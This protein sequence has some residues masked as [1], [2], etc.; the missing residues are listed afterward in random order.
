MRSILFCFLDLRGASY[1]VQESAF[2][3][4]TPQ[5]PKSGSPCGMDVTYT[6]SN[7]SYT[8][9]NQTKPKHCSTNQKQHKATTLCLV[10]SVHLQVFRTPMPWPSTTGTRGTTRLVRARAAIGRTGRQAHGAGFHFQEDHL[11][12]ELD[13]ST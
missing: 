8:L 1:M 13:T 9:Y 6:L 2:D 3:E 7:V 10:G 12:A 5:N 11:A 4:N